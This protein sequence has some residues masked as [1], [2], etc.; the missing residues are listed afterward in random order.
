MYFLFLR[1]YVI[2]HI[3]HIRKKKSAIILLIS[4]RKESLNIIDS[5]NNVIIIKEASK[6]YEDAAPIILEG[7]MDMVCEKTPIVIRIWMRMDW[8]LR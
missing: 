8:I 6:G 1:I 7:H 2:S 3:H 5:L 4:L